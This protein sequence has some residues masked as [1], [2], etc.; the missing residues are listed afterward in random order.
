MPRTAG[1]S[2]KTIAE[3]VGVS[4]VTVSRALNHDFLVE[5]TTA[6]RIRKAADKLG[7]KLPSQQRRS[8]RL[9]KGNIG[10]KALRTGTIAMLIPDPTPVGFKTPLSQ[11]IIAGIEKYLTERKI[12]LVLTHLDNGKRVPEV[13]AR[14]QADGFILRGIFSSIQLP[15]AQ[16]MQLGRFPHVSLFG[17][18]AVE[19]ENQKVLCSEDYILPDDHLIGRLALARLCSDGVADPVI[20]STLPD[21]DHLSHIYNV[22]SMTV[23]SL[24]RIN[25]FRQ[26][27]LSRN[28]SFK[29]WEVPYQDGDKIINR[30]SKYIRRSGRPA[31]IFLTRP[32]PQMLPALQQLG[33]T[34]RDGVHIYTP[35]FGQRDFTSDFSIY[36]I[37]VRP[38]ALG[39]AAAEQLLW[40]MNHPELE[41]RRIM[42]PPDPKMIKPQR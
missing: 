40:R 41:A 27:A 14:K 30:L 39:Q 16:R 37:D 26:E 11:G 3:K 29:K 4:T 9:S 17:M 8:V 25:G 13:F 24:A 21:K 18:P 36:G 33:L 20:I 5:P 34:V 42:V 15:Q 6:A 35:F 22:N 1:I 10:N 19:L 7:Y 23:A 28:V 12:R 38:E 32:F 31:G 2:L